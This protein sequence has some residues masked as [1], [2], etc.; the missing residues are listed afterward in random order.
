MKRNERRRKRYATPWLAAVAFGTALVLSACTS[1]SSQDSQS[2]GDGQP[3]EGGTINIAL[4][5]EPTTLDTMTTRSVATQIFST[6]IMEAL[7]ALDAKFEPQPMLVDTFTLSEDSTKYTMVLRDNVLFHNG[8][9]LT[10]ADVVASL[11]RFKKLTDVGKSALT[12][13]R[14]EVVDDKTFTIAF[15]RPQGNLLSALSDRQAPIYPASIL[16][17]AKPG[18]LPPESVIGTGPYKFQTWTPGVE[19]ILDKYAGYSPVEREASGVAGKKIAYADKLRFVSVPDSASRIAAIQA[20]EFNVATQFSGDDAQILE[21]APNLEAV[22]MRLG[23]L[24]LINNTTLPPLDDPDIRRAIMV[25]LNIKAFGEVLGDADNWNVSASILP[26]DTP[27]A[28]DA[29]AEDF[30]RG[31]VERAKKM[32]AEAGYDGTPITILTSNNTGTRTQAVIMQEQLEAMGIKANIDLVELTVMQT[33]R[34][35]P[36][37][38]WNMVA[39]QVSGQTDIT[40]SAYLSCGNKYS[41]ICVEEIDQALAAFSSSVGGDERQKAYNRIQEL[42]YREVPAYLTAEYWDLYAIHESLHG[43]ANEIEPFFWNTWVSS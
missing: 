33:R 16:E 34:T 42:F 21:G 25:G 35:N 30:N 17:A 12:E 37:A 3:V 24:M 6:H 4:S 18:P 31:D 40:Q 41:Y 27:L 39:S 7:F 2:Q 28:S 9:K 26:S 43:F 1:G 11:D 32:L 29:G 14:V 13:A 19:L 23:K 38:G 15:P 22:R 20:G 5:D 36:N 8:N 10:T